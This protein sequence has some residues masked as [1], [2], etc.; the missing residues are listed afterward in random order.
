[1]WKLVE[2]QVVERKI[3]LR[4]FGDFSW[5][6]GEFFGKKNWRQIQIFWKYSKNSGKRGNRMISY[7]DERGRRGGGRGVKI[8]FHG[9]DAKDAERCRRLCSFQ[10]LTR[11]AP[12]APEYFVLFLPLSLS[13]S[14]FIPVP[15]KEKKLFKFMQM[16]NIRN[17]HVVMATQISRINSGEKIGK[18]M[19][20]FQFNFKTFPQN[21]KKF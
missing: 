8:R 20:N 3:R 16:P 4:N 7:S 9:G 11:C 17:V 12:R 18:V 15:R 6:F 14:G 21:F 5:F 10:Y 1:M 2:I 19:R 13:L